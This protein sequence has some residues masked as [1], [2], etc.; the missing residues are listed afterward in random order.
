M[1]LPWQPFGHDTHTI[2][3]NDEVGH[4]NCICLRNYKSIQYHLHLH[5]KIDNA[6]DIHYIFRYK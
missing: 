6:S 3:H 1:E 2:A 4:F 5:Y